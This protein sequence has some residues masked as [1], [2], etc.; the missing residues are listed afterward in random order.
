MVDDRGVNDAGDGSRRA[1]GFMQRL[2]EVPPL[3]EVREPLQ[4]LPDVDGGAVQIEEA[5]C[6]D[7]DGNDAASQNRPHQQATLLDVVDHAKL[8]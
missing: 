4:E 5:L 6:E 7:R 3:Q 1:G 8:S 2:G